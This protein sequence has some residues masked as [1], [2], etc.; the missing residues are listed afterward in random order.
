MTFSSS[1]LLSNL[2]CKTF[3]SFIH[4][5]FF[6]SQ[7]DGSLERLIKES[8]QLKSSYGHYF[9][10]VV[11]N[12]DIEETIRILEQTMENLPS[13]TQWI[14][15]SWIYWCTDERIYI[16]KPLSSVLYSR[17]LCTYKSW[18]NPTNSSPSS[19][20][21]LPFYTYIHIYIWQLLLRILGYIR[22]N[23]KKKKGK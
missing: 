4:K 7:Y 2:Q 11:V 16:C 17:I 20:P 23:R 19:L 22:V 3:F 12:N 14:P 21:I 13:S 18:G 1:L 15:V 8:A 10:L 6:L 9:D 5:I